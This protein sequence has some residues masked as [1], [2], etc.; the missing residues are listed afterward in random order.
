MMVKI[1]NYD[2]YYINESGNILDTNLN[3]IR[4]SVDEDGL[5]YVTLD[6]E[7]KYVH[8]LVSD[9]FFKNPMRYRY[10]IHKDGDILNNHV[11]NLTFSDKS[12]IIENNLNSNGYTKGSRD[13]EVFNEETGD[14][15]LCHGREEVSDLIQY[16]LISLKNMVGNGRKIFLGP[17]KGYQIRIVRKVVNQYELLK[18]NRN[19]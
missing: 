5:I 7:K 16:S 18:R 10:T 19:V 12:E 3:L 2:N 4:T 8:D 15:I 14:V 17:Y 13:Y 11:S 9:T 1:P 6:K